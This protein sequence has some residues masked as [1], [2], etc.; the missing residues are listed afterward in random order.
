MYY[1]S[2]LF[3]L[4]VASG[5]SQQAS[6]YFPAANGYKWYSKTVVLDSLN[7]EVD[8]LTAYSIDTLAGETT[9]KG[10]QAKYILGKTGVY[11][12]VSFQPYIDTSFVSLSGTEARTYFGL[13]N[14]NALLG[15]IDTT[16][17]DST[18]LGVLGLIS[19]V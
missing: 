6:D 7:Q 19:S 8:S 1:L 13:G 17:I 16:S 18:L 4:L 15:L 11:E 2:L 10:Y 5:F 9:Y 12:T 3:V 14:I